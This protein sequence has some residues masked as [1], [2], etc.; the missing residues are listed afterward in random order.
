MSYVT[1]NS[2]VEI[3]KNIPWDNTYEHTLYFASSQSHPASYY[4]NL[5]FSALRTT[6]QLQNKY[7]VKQ[8]NSYSYQRKSKDSIKI[9]VAPDTIY[10]YNYMRFKNT[11][12]GNKWFY[13]FIT[14]VE[15]VN[16]NTALVHYEIDVIQTYIDEM[17]LK[18]SYVEREHSRTDHIGENLEDEPVSFSDMYAIKVDAPYNFD[19]YNI[20]LFYADDDTSAEVDPPASITATVI[21]KV[22][23]GT[24]VGEPV[25]IYIRIQ[26][27]TNLGSDNVSF[28]NNSG[29]V[30]VSG[31]DYPWTFDATNGILKID[32][33]WDGTI[34]AGAIKVNVNPT[35]YASKRYTNSTGLTLRTM[36]VNDTITLNEVSS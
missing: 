7:Q 11:S 16:E 32:G 36:N 29:T 30:T 20:L 31:V 19:D 23:S 34:P 35:I 17:I 21:S 28:E 18:Q 9:G 15:Y 12:H 26:V 5:L 1:P 2:T 14:D 33:T 13:A 3:F 25:F 8:F 27:T 4:Q 24:Q 6:V 22:L 10:D